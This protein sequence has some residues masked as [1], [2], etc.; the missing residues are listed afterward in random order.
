TTR[1]TRPSQL[2]PVLLDTSPLLSVPSYVCLTTHIGRPHPR[3]H[4][5][6][7]SRPRVP[8]P[9]Y[10]KPHDRH[11]RHSSRRYGARKVLAVARNAPRAAQPRAARRGDV[12]AP[13]RLDGVDSGQRE[14]AGARRKRGL[15]DPPRSPPDPTRGP[16]VL[17]QSRRRAPGPP[18]PPSW[19]R[20]ARR[21]GGHV[22]CL[23]RFTRPPLRAAT[24]AWP[25]SWLRGD[26]SGRQP[27]RGAAA[28]PRAGPSRGSGRSHGI[29][30]P[31]EADEQPGTR[32]DARR[33]ARGPRPAHPGLRG[34]PRK[35]RRARL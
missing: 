6:P 34:R 35:P 5:E 7:T 2:V 1:R 28:H 10:T 3:K 22:P 11:H 32:R 16:D 24:P 29:A 25:H 15:L 19:R 14:D 27:T 23:W 12:P 30:G 18:G 33:Y 4:D 26:G 8:S 20:G 17:A 13:L 21:V 31:R 9:L